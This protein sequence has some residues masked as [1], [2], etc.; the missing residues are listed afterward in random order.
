MMFRLLHDGLIIGHSQLEDLL[1]ISCST[2]G[3]VCPSKDFAQFKA[4]NPPKKLAQKEGVY[5]TT[6]TLATR[7]NVALPCK[8][9]ILIEDNEGL[10]VEAKYIDAELYQ[11]LFG[12]EIAELNQLMHEHMERHPEFGLKEFLKRKTVH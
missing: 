10:W 7:D 6:P 2:G 11:S 9:F 5:W 1:P 8:E 3:D 12:E 4:N